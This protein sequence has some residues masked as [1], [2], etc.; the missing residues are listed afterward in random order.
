M[1]DG[2]DQRLDELFKAARGERFDSAF[3][4]EHFETRLMARISERRSRP[5]PWY[6]QAWRLVPAFFAVAATITIVTFS[7][8][9]R[10]SGDMFAVLANDQE[11]LVVSGYGIGE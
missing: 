3:L 2:K 1:R 4:E 11:D 7:F 9:P 10:D 8:T 6:A 5:A